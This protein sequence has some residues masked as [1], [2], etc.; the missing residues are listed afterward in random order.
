MAASRLTNKASEV[1]RQEAETLSPAVSLPTE[2][3]DEV[4]V[5]REEMGCELS[6]SAHAQFLSPGRTSSL[7]S[8]RESSTSEKLKLATVMN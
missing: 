2:V 1:L 4:N 6:S 5:Q 8:M 3:T 7:A